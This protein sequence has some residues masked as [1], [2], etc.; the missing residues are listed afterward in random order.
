[1]AAAVSMTDNGS[2]LI[3]FLEVGWRRRLRARDTAASCS[4][5]LRASTAAC[6]APQFPATLLS[7]PPRFAFFFRAKI[8]TTAETLSAA[9]EKG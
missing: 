2:G 4:A 1:M 9:C 3:L 7:S 5:L 6:S 8:Y